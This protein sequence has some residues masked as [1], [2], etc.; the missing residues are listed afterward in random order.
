LIAGG[1]R[2]KRRHTPL[3]SPTSPGESGRSNLDYTRPT[4]GGLTLV[5]TLWTTD[6]LTPISP[7]EPPMIQYATRGLATLWEHQALPASDALA[8]LLGATRAGL[9]ID[10]RTPASSTELAVRLGVWTGWPCC[11]LMAEAARLHL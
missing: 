5:P 8:G 1:D 4:T 3:S 10:L 6:A 7:D 11:K 9:L 2:S